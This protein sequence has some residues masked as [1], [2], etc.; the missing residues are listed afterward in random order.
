MKNRNLPFF[1]GGCYIYK[2]LFHSIMCICI[3]KEYKEL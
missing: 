2:D 1:E 3:Q